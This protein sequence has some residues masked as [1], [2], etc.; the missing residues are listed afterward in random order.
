[1]LSE[2]LGRTEALSFRPKILLEPFAVDGGQLRIREL[3]L[4]LVRQEL[5]V[6]VRL[7]D[8]HRLLEIREANVALQI[9]GPE[10]PR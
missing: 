8:E 6:R 2:D 4:V 5:E 1:M 3:G 10:T 9:V 7:Q